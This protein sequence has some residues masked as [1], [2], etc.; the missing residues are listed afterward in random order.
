[1]LL[2]WDGR[3]DLPGIFSLMFLMLSTIASIL[4][5]LDLEELLPFLLV[6]VCGES[7]NSSY[8]LSPFSIHAMRIPSVILL[9][10]PISFNK[11]YSSNKNRQLPST[12]CFSDLCHQWLLNLSVKLLKPIKR[13]HAAVSSTD[14]SST[15]F[16]S[17]ANSRIEISDRVLI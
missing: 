4:S 3:S 13:S 16:G 2:S 7:S 6:E 11:F 1:V 17:I 15:D 8:S 5:I 9:L 10:M 14:H 12:L